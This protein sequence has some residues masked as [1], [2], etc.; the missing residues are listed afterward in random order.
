M[1]FDY[2]QDKF[3]AMILEQ[4]DTLPSGPTEKTETEI[5]FCTLAVM[6]TNKKKG[7]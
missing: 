1:V 5:K 2:D 6:P 7:I 3:N 4:Q